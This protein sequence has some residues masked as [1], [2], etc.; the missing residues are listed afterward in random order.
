MQRIKP[1]TDTDECELHQKNF[2]ASSVELSLDIDNLHP[3]TQYTVSVSA[4][5]SCE[6][7]AE[8]G[9]NTTDEAGN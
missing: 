3:Y 4:V 8:Q 7:L 1:K 6:G 9:K 2:T 5:T